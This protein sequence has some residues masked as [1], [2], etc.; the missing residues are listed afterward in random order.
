MSRAT[1]IAVKIYQ[2]LDLIGDPGIQDHQ[3]PPLRNAPS[4]FW[5]F[6]RFVID[7]FGKGLKPAEEKRAAE[8][9]RQQLDAT[10]SALHE[11]VAE[12]RWRELDA[13]QQRW[14]DS[15]IRLEPGDEVTVIAQGHLHLNRALDVRVAPDAAL[16]YRID[17]GPIHKLPRCATVI[18][19]DRPGTLQWMARLPGGFADPQGTLSSELPTPKASGQFQV[20][21]IRWRGDSD[22]ALRRAKNL[23]PD[24]FE[25]ALDSLQPR[26]H[27]PRGWQ[28]LWRL[29]ESDIYHTDAKDGSLC[30]HSDTSGGI[31]Q[32]PL[33]LPLTPG[34]RLHWRWLTEALPSNIAEHIQPTHDYLSLAVEFDNGL[35]LT[36]MWSSQLPVDTIFQCPLPWWDQR[37]T[38]WV[39][40]ND[41]AELGQWLDER[42]NLWADYK[43]AIG[44]PLPDRV[45]GVW[46]IANSL[47]QRGQGRCRYRGIRFKDKNRETIVHP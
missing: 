6:W 45:V 34:L 35:D 22:Q 24:L 9:F 37:E 32:Y 33:N 19:A 17:A 16:W 5:A 31:L 40:R 42:R 7:R 13:D 11:W 21:M 26:Q 10:A 43:R 47:F 28:Y 39:I 2:M 12:M 29:G 25:A 4:P 23:E 27:A 30:C 41:P 8:Q 20:G 14:E 15:G 18:R 38:H 46:L 1:P 44:G 36:Y 3:Q